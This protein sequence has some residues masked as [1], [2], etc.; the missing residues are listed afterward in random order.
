MP[1]YDIQILLTE[2]N[3]VGPASGMVGSDSSKVQKAKRK[4]GLIPY[5]PHLNHYLSRLS[6]I[7]EVSK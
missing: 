2:K 3:K 6:L 5:N 7:T 1:V 4:E